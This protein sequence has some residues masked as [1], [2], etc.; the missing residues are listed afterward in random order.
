MQP[1]HAI[2]TQIVKYGRQSASMDFIIPNKMQFTIL[3]SA[4]LLLFDTACLTP[5]CAK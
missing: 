4:L 1:S 2:A 5:S 3:H